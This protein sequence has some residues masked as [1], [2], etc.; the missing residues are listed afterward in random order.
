MGTSVA[1][2]SLEKDIDMS[3]KELDNVISEISNVFSCVVDG[4][5]L[6]LQNMVRVFAK[7]DPSSSTIVC[8]AFC[9]MFGVIAIDSGSTDKVENVFWS[10]HNGKV[11]RAVSL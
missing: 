4:M 1:I 11:R 7:T 6:G 2:H 8:G 5:Q 10:I 3:L 9:A